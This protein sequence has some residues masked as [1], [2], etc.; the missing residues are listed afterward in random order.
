MN[1]RVKMANEVKRGSLT[2]LLASRLKTR[3][4]E[5]VCKSYD[6]I[7]NIAII[8]LH[9]SSKH[10]SKIVAEAIMRANKRVKAMLRQAGPVLS[11]FRT[12]KLGGWQA[13]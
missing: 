6:I 9:E 5:Y 11:D 1:Q 2:A 7:G 8:R 4:L 13:K 12:R 3:K 10:L